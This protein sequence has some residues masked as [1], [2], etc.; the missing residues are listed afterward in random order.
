MLLAYI[1]HQNIQSHGAENERAFRST[2]T[3]HR[4]LNR[5]CTEQFKPLHFTDIHKSKKNTKK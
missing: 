5:L 3:Q 4:I 1:I 2:R